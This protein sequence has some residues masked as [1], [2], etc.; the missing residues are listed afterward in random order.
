M[1]VSL[2]DSSSSEAYSHTYMVKKL[3]QHFGNDLVLTNLPGKVTVVTLRRKASSILHEFFTSNKKNENRAEEKLLLIKTAA[4]LISEDIKQITTDQ[5]KYPALDELS[6]EAAL[7]FL[8]TSLRHFL[9]CILCPKKSDIRIASIGQ[10]IMQASRPRGIQAPLQIGLGVHLHSQYASYNMLETLHSLGFSCSHAEVRNFEKNAATC[11][12]TDIPNYSNQFIQYSADNVDH[13]LCTIDGN[14]TF[15]G[16]GIMATVTPNITAK[17][18]VSRIVVT[19]KD[20]AAVSQIRITFHQKILNNNLFTFRTPNDFENETNSCLDILWKSSILFQ[21]PRPNWSGMMQIIHR[22]PHPGKSSTFFL[23][24]IDLKPTDPT[25]IYS[26]LHFV[27]E[28]AKRHN[29]SPILT[30][31]QPLYWKAFMIVLEEPDHSYLKQIVLRLGGF[32]TLICFIGAIGY[33]MAG[34][35]LEQVLETIYASVEH[36][37]SGKAISR[38]I[39]GHLLVDAVLNG[40]IF[41]DL[42]KT[43]SLFTEQTSMKVTDTGD[44]LLEFT[45]LKDLYES[46]MAFQTPVNELT[47]NQIL[48]EIKKDYT[49]NAKI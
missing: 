23:P 41:S 40:I 4:A 15:H 42:I 6:R 5:N 46:V 11:Q 1:K 38:A 48:L 19:E 32:H 44:E 34:S 43:P 12:G 30:F 22:G 31:D 29:S 28:H 25:C 49:R 7:N 20:I 36:I 16:M 39:R 8:P 10:A 2:S 13:N 3:K 45:L 9:E 21:K 27:A 18:L 37:F 26:T 14:G 24:M 33:L 35:G 47:V 17:Q